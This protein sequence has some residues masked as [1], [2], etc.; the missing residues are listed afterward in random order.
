M[1]VTREQ[2]ERNRERVVEAA[3]R[4]FRERGFEGVG[5]ADLMKSAGLTHGGFY[6]Q[7]NSKEHLMVEACGQAQE[8]SDQKWRELLEHTPKKPLSA[9]ASFYLSPQHRDNPGTGCVVAALSIDAARQGTPVRAA[10]TEAVKRMVAF[11][12]QFVPG[13]SA[14]TRR[15]EALVTYASMVGAIVLARTVNDTALSEEIL[16]AA[17]SQLAQHDKAGLE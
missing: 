12:E 1:K 10:F 13:R 8:E 14:K 6:G 17:H 3:A 4:L 5:V 9:I 15:R 11:L 16:E 2:A 7:F